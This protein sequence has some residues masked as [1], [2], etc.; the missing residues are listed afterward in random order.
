MKLLIQF[1]NLCFLAGLVIAHE[2]HD[3]PQMPLDYVRYPYQARYPGDN[4]GDLRS[5]PSVVVRGLTGTLYHTVTADSIFSGITTFAMLPWVQCL[6]RDKTT[7]FDIAFIGAPFVRSFSRKMGINTDMTLSRTP[8]PRPAL[9]LGSGLLV[10]ER[11]L[12]ASLFTA[13]TT[14]HLR[15]IPSF[16][17]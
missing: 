1:I 8:A 5:A 13:D 6:G 15:S 3:D 17:A 4:D 9:V 16:L 12:A 11:A 7:A 10:S 2:G 14:Y